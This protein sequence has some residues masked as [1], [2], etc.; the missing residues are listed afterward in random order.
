MLP[1]NTPGR[2]ND[3][4]ELELRQ[5]QHARVEDRIRNAK[6][7]GLR[8]LPCQELH[9]NAAWVELALAAADL[10]TWAQAL[11]F[12]GTLRK[13]EPKRLRYRALHVAGRLVR[14]GRRIILR[15]DQNWPWA[16]HLATAFNR[17]RAAPWP[18]EANPTRQSTT[19]NSVKTP[20]GSPAGPAA[21]PNHPAGPDAITIALAN[22]HSGVMK[23]AG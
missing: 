3:I 9:T 2:G 17:L 4:A 19:R 5:R 20:P 15:L 7:R 23:H 13:L 16:N 8:N 1:T 14:I 21:C 22:D 11:C 12:T 18:A 6:D 10:T